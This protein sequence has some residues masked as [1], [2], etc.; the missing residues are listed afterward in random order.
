MDSHETSPA[1][2]LARSSI[3]LPLSVMIFGGYARAGGLSSASNK[4]FAMLLGFAM[5]FASLAGFACGIAALCRRRGE[6]SVLVRSVVGLIINCSLLLL[7]FSAFVQGFNRGYARSVKARESMASVK[8]TLDQTQDNL[9]RSFDSTN[10]IKS[11]P[12]VLDKTVDVLKKASQDAQGESALVLEASTAYLGELQR[13]TRLYDVELKSIESGRLLDASTLKTKEQIEQ[14]RQVVQNFLKAN[15]DI[16]RFVASSE[17]SFRNELVRRKVSQTR[18][19][20]EVA[21]FRESMQSRRPLLRA[22]R[23]S[24]KNIGDSMLAVL[25]LLESNWGTWKYDPISAEVLFSDTATLDEYKTHL[26]EI[27]AAGKQ[28]VAL[29]QRFL[30]LR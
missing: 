20:R 16:D 22:I 15:S 10:G 7:F 19:D 30:S 6:V 8:R 4:P 13:L 1:L 2:R 17:S 14:R 11:D 26:E 3:W 18:M 23:A 28:Q 25:N 21:A 9:R 24:D 29:Q 27:G 5:I 12:A